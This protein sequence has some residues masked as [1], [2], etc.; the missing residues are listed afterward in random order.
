MYLTEVNM[1]I[2]PLTRATIILFSMIPISS[3]IFL[4]KG[5]RAAAASS[6]ETNQHKLS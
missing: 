1:N 5:G 2:S 4:M 3:S 6:G